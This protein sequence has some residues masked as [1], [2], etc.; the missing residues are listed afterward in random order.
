M[1]R[2][3]TGAYAFM[4]ILS[5]CSTLMMLAGT[6]FLLG[7]LNVTKLLLATVTVGALISTFTPPA[8]VNIAFG[9]MLVFGGIGVG[10]IAVLMGN[11][12]GSRRN[13]G[14]SD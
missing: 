4:I 14:R 1:S 7:V 13:F 5:M 11:R 6:L 12:S 3:Q 2:Q 10:L 8:W 9:T